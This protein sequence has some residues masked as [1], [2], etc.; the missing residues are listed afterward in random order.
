MVPSCSR[1]P[2]TS[3]LV[4]LLLVV[5]TTSCGLFDAVSNEPTA[6]LQVELLTGPESPTNETA[7]K[8]EFQCIEAEACEFTCRLNDEDAEACLS[9]VEYMELDDGNHQFEVVADVK[10]ESESAIWEWTIDTVAPSV[11]ELE[12]PRQYTNQRAATFSFDCSKE[13]CRFD[14]RLDDEE[15]KECESGI[16]YTDLDDDSYRFSVRAEDGLGNV[17]PTETLEWMV[18]SQISTVTGGAPVTFVI[19]ANE[20]CPAEDPDCVAPETS[21]APAD[22]ALT[23]YESSVFVDLLELF[24]DVEDIEDGLLELEIT[25]IDYEVVDN[26]S[27]FFIPELT[28]YVGP[29]GSEDIEDDDVIPLAVLPP[30]S[31]GTEPQGQAD[32]QESNRRSATDLFKA[33]EFSLLV[34]TQPIVKEGQPMPPSGAVEYDVIFNMEITTGPTED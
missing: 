28:L 1:R 3:T 8:F 29:M 10:G 9:P 27:T 25:S 5:N 34:F 32:I 16:T 21:P 15:L 7:A 12:G 24:Y 13:D 18:N 2:V 22:V 33:L 26:N 14:C 11:I 30:V 19:D 23:P 31:A 17:G 20:L 6:P 4:I